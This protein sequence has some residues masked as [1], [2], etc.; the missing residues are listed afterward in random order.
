MKVYFISGLAADRRVFKYIELPSGF[1]AVHLDW[2]PP[3]KNET[4]ESYSLRLAE[5]IDPGEP[6]ALV[7]LSMGGMIAAEITKK[8]KP[9]ACVLLCSVPTY[10]HFPTHFRWAYNLRLHR[11]VPVSLVKMASIIKR[12]FTADNKE[13]HQLIREVIKDSDP[14][15]IRWAMHAILSWRNETIPDSL[16]QIHGTKDEILPIRFTQP[17]HTIK[18]GNHL[19]IMSK[20]SELNSFLHEALTSIVKTGG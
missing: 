10:R 18:N 12:G 8:L 19:M 16:W 14:K 17:T 11:L 5:P 3:N 4:L 1:E 20:A 15:F 7:G 6:F 2:I 9:E 13:D